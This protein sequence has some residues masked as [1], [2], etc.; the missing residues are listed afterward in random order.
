MCSINVIFTLPQIKQTFDWAHLAVLFHLPFLLSIPC[1]YIYIYIS[2]PL[3]NDTVAQLIP[4]PFLASHSP[5]SVPHWCFSSVFALPS[6]TLTCLSERINSSQT[7]LALLGGLHWLVLANALR[8]TP[9]HA[10]SHAAHS[11]LLAPLQSLVCTHSLS[12]HAV[13]FSCK[14]MQLIYFNC[15]LIP[16]LSWSPCLLLSLS[17]Y[18][19]LSLPLSHF[20]SLSH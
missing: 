9:A 12:S 17:L 1:L 2:N 6:F 11:C 16:A 20:L 8:S 19:Y 7:L 10:Q 3:Y 14:H 13:I 4:P 15:F 5:T 18:V